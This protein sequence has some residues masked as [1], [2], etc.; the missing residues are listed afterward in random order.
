M[1]KI[2]KWI[3]LYFKGRDV[4]NTKMSEPLY[5]RMVKFPQK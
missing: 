1:K 5:P 3:Y 2:F 4:W